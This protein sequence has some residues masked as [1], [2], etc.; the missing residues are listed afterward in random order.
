MAEFHYQ[1]RNQKGELVSGKRQA[2]SEVILAKLLRQENLIP[3]SINSQKAKSKNKEIHIKLPKLFKKKVDKDELQMFCRQMYTLIKAGIPVMMA[4]ARLAETTRDETLKEALEMVLKRLNQG[5]ELSFALKERRDIFSNLFINLVRVGE[6]TGKLDSVFLYIADYLSLE[7]ET[8]KKVKTAL[9][10]PILVLVSTLVAILVINIFVVPTFAKMFKSANVELPLPTIIL[11]TT[12]DFI[13]NYWYLLVLITAVGIWG[14]RRFV[15]T[16]QGALKW[17]S[18]QLKIPIIGWLIHRIVLARFTRLYALVLKAGVTALEGIQLVGASTGNAYI[19]KKVKGV[20]DLI[21]RGNSIG[22]SVSEIDLFPPLVV[23][24]ITLGEESGQIDTM[25][26]DVAD[27]YEREVAYDLVRLSD[28]IEPIMLVIMA[29]MV[30][31]LAFGV[32]L[33]MW[34]MMSAVGRH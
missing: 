22:N 33:P 4:I 5:R 8:K 10:Y 16:P 24:M 29:V 13:L 9:R 2:D 1:C 31:I 26:D 21:A 6:T 11:M 32:F 3:I 15:R 20:T 7:T 27:F 28:T 14:I 30:L 17:S 19:E 34:D 23:Q 12:S 18:W 25:L